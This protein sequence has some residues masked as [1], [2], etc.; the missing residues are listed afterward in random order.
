MTTLDQL[1]YNILNL[2]KGGRPSDDSLPSLRQI[3]FWIK[4]YRN[5]LVKQ[6]DDKDRTLDSVLLQDLGCVPVKL[7]DA[8]ECCELSVCD[9]I[10]RTVDKIPVPISLSYNEA[11]SYVGSIDLQQPYQKISVTHIPWFQYDKYIFNLAKYYYKGGYIY[12]AN[13]KETDYIKVIGAF[14]DPEEVAKYNHCGTNGVCYDNSSQFPI[15]GYMIPIITQMIVEK[16]LNIVLKTKEDTTN[17]SQ[18]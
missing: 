16:E 15:A 12:V 14:E 9:R 18:N 11:L 8:A 5:I 7:V 4:H 6:Q 1:T 17:D 10:L 13:E 3:A 2:A